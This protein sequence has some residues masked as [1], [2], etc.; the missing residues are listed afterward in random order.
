MGKYLT[1]LALGVLA[2][3]SCG[4][5]PEECT[6]RFLNWDNSYLGADIVK[7]GEDAEYTGNT[8]HGPDTAKYT[9]VF[10]GWDKSLANITSDCERVAQYDKKLAQYTVSFVNYDGTALYSTVVDYDGTA[11]YVGGTPTK[12][13]D[14][15]SVYTFSGWDV[16][17]DHIQSNVTAKAQYRPNDRIYTLTFKNWDGTI[18]S[19]QTGTWDAKIAYSGETPKRPDDESGSF[20]FDYWSPDFR[21]YVDGN[22]IYTATF[23]H[24][25][26]S[27]DVTFRNWDG[28]LLASQKVEWGKSASYGGVPTKPST[29]DHTYSFAGWDKPMGPI[30]EN[31]VFYPVYTEAVR[32]YTVKFLN[33]DGCVLET[34]TVAYNSYASYGGGTPTYPSDDYIYT[35]DRWDKAPSETPI[36]GDTVFTATYTKETNYSAFAFSLLEDGTYSISG[37]LSYSKTYHYTQLHVPS[38]YQGIAVTVIAKNAF[39]SCTELTTVVLP[40]SITAIGDSAFSGCSY[41]TSFIFS[42]NLLTIGASAFSGNSRLTAVELPSS[43]TSVAYA[44]FEG[45]SSIKEVNLPDGITALPNEVFQNC[46]SLAKVHLGSAVKEIGQHA[47]YSCTALSTINMPE[48]L[49]TIGDWAFYNC[50]NLSGANFPSGLETIGYCAFDGCALLG[51]MD[52]PASLTTLGGSAFLSCKSLTKATIPST[53]TSIPSYCFSNCASLAEVVIGSGVMSIGQY[54]FSG[55]RALKKITFVQG[56]LLYLELESFQ[57]CSS[58][59]EVFLP[60]GLTTISS[61][62]FEGCTALKEVF[63]PKSVT[64]IRANAI[65]ANYATKIYCETTTKPTSGWNEQWNGG[66]NNAYFYSES[67]PTATGKYWHYV[68]EVITEW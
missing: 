57:N 32:K 16:A 36:V 29:A 24:K 7:Y 2:L 40:D 30:K 1:V 52:L 50:L 56:S 46:S 25:L 67:Q 43:L 64:T 28:S 15:Q 47:F 61:N 12:P 3:S 5:H 42:K 21:G 20:T 18:L 48:K 59:S 19:T 8:P 53:I 27:Y 37:I 45:C 54:S 39:V 49:K 60:E 44:S 13:Q 68:H 9:Y 58:L 62:A 4:A 22:K 23:A 31:T 66:Y 11:S 63:I 10:S 35:F 38:Q 14:Q 65:P 26:F 55:C 34:D 6:V 41:L 51:P 33:Q 17:L